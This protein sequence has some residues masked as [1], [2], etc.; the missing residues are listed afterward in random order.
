MT[1]R[2]RNINTP[3]P[4]PSHLAGMQSTLAPRVPTRDEA[5]ITWRTNLLYLVAK[6][7]SHVQ[8]YSTPMECRPPDASVHGISQARIVEW[9]VIS[10]SRGSS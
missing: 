5:P 10:F 7:L 4:S 3:A 8:L 6:S 9:L 1:N 2:N